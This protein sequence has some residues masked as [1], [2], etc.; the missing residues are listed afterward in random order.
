M[1]L[2]QGIQGERPGLILKLL[3]KERIEKRGDEQD[4]VC[5]ETPRFQDL[6]AIHNEILAQ[7]GQGYF[8]LDSLQIEQTPLEKAL[9]C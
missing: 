4:R 8:L 2:D 6:V 5:P 1:D 9:F 7:E 3:K